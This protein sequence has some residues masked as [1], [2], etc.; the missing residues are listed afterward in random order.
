MSTIAH[1][2]MYMVLY[3]LALLEVV[4]NANDTYLKILH[5]IQTVM[6]SNDNRFIELSEMLWDVIVWKLKI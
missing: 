6:V 5:I 4:W 3:Y 1:I 2:Y